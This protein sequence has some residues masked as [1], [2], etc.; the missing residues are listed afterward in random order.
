MNWKNVLWAS[1]LLLLAPALVSGM[2][3]GS[4]GTDGILSITGTGTTNIDLSLA[5][6][7]IWTTPGTGSGVYDSTKWAVVFK[8][9]SVYVATGKTV[10]FTNHP[11]GAP[12]VWLVL[13]GA[14][15]DG[16]VRLDG[17]GYRTNGAFAVGG[18]G[19]FRGGRSWLSAQSLGSAGLGPV[20]EAMLPT[21]MVRGGGTARREAD[22]KVEPPTVTPGSFPCWAVVAARGRDRTDTAVAEA[23]ARFCWLLVKPSPSRAASRQTVVAVGRRGAAVPV[24]A[25]A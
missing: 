20:A 2:D 6:T 8:Y 4:D 7:A 21:P 22:R 25:S 19:G 13:R 9:D 12:V 17:Q 16:T 5:T 10:T 3:V 15:I 1:L 14:R 11:S 23:V 24:V 18:P